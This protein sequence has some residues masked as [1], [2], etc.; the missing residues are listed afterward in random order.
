VLDARLRGINS[1]L[2]LPPPRSSYESRVDGRYRI[3]L[4][5]FP[6][7][8]GLVEER[9]ARGTISIPSQ[10]LIQNHDTYDTIFN[11]SINPILHWGDHTIAFSPGLQFTV[12]RDTESPV[13]LNQNLFRQFLYVYSSPFWNWL[14]F[15]G[16]AIH[17]A[18]PFTEQNL[19]SRDNS[20]SLNFI[21]GR[22]WGKTALITGYQARDVQ[23]HPLISEYYTT[24]AYAG[25]RRKFGDHLEASIFGEYLRSWRVQDTY[26]A[27]AQAMRPAFRL[28]YVASKHWTVQASGVWSRGEGFHAYDNVND[29]F[30][31]TYVRPVERS[32]HDGVQ[33]VPVRYP[34]SISFGMQQQSF[35]D[36]Q[37]N[38]RNTF[39]PVI[40]LN[41]F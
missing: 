20:A 7:I 37:G 25:V 19:S 41:I 34:M 17:E 5:G 24:S 16:D 38:N 21:V 13:Q 1:P 29:Q 8:S 9:N 3:H 6:S 2:L 4:G 18:G 35:Y 23:F 26:Y 32:L 40:R 39:L 36:F 28:N 33:D 22:P 10:L 31:V 11:G 27:I 14:S 12:R 15:S 30:L